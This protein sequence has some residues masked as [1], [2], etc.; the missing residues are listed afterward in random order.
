MHRDA[1]LQ[2]NVARVN[3]THGD[4]LS[5]LHHATGPDHA[6]SDAATMSTSLVDSLAACAAPRPV[7]PSTPSAT[8]S[9]TTSR[10]LYL[11]GIG[12]SIGATAS[13]YLYWVAA[14]CAMSE[15]DSAAVC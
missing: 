10:Y 15:C 13:Q 2:T 1:G 8:L 9:S 14:G 3:W 4:A 6:L 7:A 12:C 5:P 11:G